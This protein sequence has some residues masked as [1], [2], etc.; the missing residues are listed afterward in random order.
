[1]KKLRDLE[2]QTKNIIAVLW[3]K[4]T[5]SSLVLTN[6]EIRK[7]GIQ[8]YASSVPPTSSVGR[9]DATF[10]M[11]F[12]REEQQNTH[13]LDNPRPPWLAFEDG[14][15]GTEASLLLTE[16]VDESSVSCE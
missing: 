14:L 1:V 2:K 8:C 4:E 9:K 7:H 10:E 11:S 3:T 15:I 13:C 16:K 5:S 12:W 6:N